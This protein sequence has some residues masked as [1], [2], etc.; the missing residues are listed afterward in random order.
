MQSH[1]FLHDGFNEG[2]AAFFHGIELGGRID[3]NVHGRIDVKVFQGTAYAGEK[4]LR[5]CL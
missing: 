3:K 2:V 1:P 4:N 5:Q